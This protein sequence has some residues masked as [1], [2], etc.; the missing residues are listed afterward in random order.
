MRKR[1]G[2][3]SG[4]CRAIF[5]LSFFKWSSHPHPHQHFPRQGQVTL[6]IIIGIVLLFS[7][8]GIMYVTQAVK[9]APLVAAEEPIIADAPQ[10]FLPLQ[11]YTENCLTRLGKHGLRILG[12]QGGYIDPQLVGKFSATNPTDADGID[13]QPLKV[14]YWHYNSKPNQEKGITF[15]SLQ[16]KLYDEEDPEMSIESQLSRFVEQQLDSC[17]QSY[18]PFSSQGFTVIQDAQRE[19]EVTV[20]DTTVSFLLKQK[21]VARKG[22]EHSF[23]RFYVKIPL[24]LKAYY[25]TAAQLAVAEQNLTYLERQA[26]DLL[27]IYSGVDTQRLPPTTAIKFDIIP[28]VSWTVKDVEGKLR[29]MLISSVPLLRFLESTDFYRLQLPESSLSGGLKTTQAVYDQMIIPLDLTEG[30]L[31]HFDYLGWPLYFDVNDK[32][33]TIRPSSLS[34][35]LPPFFQFHLQTYY[36]VYDLSYPVLV[37]IQD[38]MALDGEG[39][40]LVMALEANIRNNAPPDEAGVVIPPL[41]AQKSM[42]CDKNQF[43][44]ELIRSVVLDSQTREPLPAVQIGLTIPEEDDCLIGLTDDQGKLEEKYP[45]VYGGVA[46]FFKPEYLTEFYPIDTYRY[47]EQPGIIGYATAELPEQAI[48]LHPY[49]NINITVRKKLIEKCVGERCSGGDGGL[50]ASGGTLVASGGVPVAS[51]IPEMLEDLHVW[52][53]TG[54]TQ[55]LTAAETATLT[56]ERVGDLEPQR[57]QEA[58]QTAVSITGNNENNKNN[59]NSHLENSQQEVQLVPGIYKITGILLTRE[60]IIIPA[61]ERCITILFSEECVPFKETKLD[62]FILGQVQWDLPE[63]YITITPDQLYGSGELILYFP[64]VNLPGV[65]AEPHIRVLEDL[66]VVGDLGKIS[67]KT[68]IRRALQPSWR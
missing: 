26:L 8:A 64:T 20:R 25:D 6:F 7:F 17:L 36:T 59:K 34:T 1:G 39:Y 28:T 13:L 22:E 60:P 2:C 14:P 47:K 46:S 43:D 23:D 32:S 57:Q 15:S 16:P 67:Q 31:T 27:Q 24:R 58:Y 45:A 3:S 61:E 56:F 38:E 54:R 51:F 50:V 30:L 48:S 18:A 19:V 21:I 53:F 5:L 49:K 35:G 52:R 9:K 44:T 33:G 68:E 65:P 10:T 29:N 37:T 12:Q 66:Q 42:V 55:D 4:I 62:S 11:R 40:S 41:R 63:T